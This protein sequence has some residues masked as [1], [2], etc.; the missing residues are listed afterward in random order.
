M[1]SVIV[2]LEMVYE[3][4]FASLHLSMDEVQHLCVATDVDGGGEAGCVCITKRAIGQREAAHNHC[5]YSD[6]DALDGVNEQNA[7]FAVKTIIP[8]HFF[9]GYTRGK[10][11][12]A[13]LETERIEIGRE[14]II[15]DG[16]KD[17]PSEGLVVNDK[18][19]VFQKLDLLVNG[20]RRL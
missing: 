12:G 10:V 11:V 18:I 4:F 1:G 5:L 9:N 13:V 17:A 16:C 14:A 15:A 19:P 2:G 6:L 20:Q 8:P 3:F 7:H